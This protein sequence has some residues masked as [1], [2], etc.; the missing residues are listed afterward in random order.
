MRFI[1][2]VTCCVVGALGAQ[3]SRAR[4]TLPGFRDPFP[5]E[6]VTTSY[7]LNAPIGRAFA[8]IKGAFDDLRVPLDVND[9]RG[10]IV[11]NRSIKSVVAFAGYRLSRLVDCGSSPTGQNADTFRV[12]LV[13][14][15]LLD[16]TDATHT[17]VRVGFVGGAEPVAGAMRQ[18]VQCG[19]TGVIEA[20]LIELANKHL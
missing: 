14:L 12:S 20:R 17:K 1:L 4:I 19:S 16:S 18:G 11:G 13:L 7:D 3:P 5:I 10:E 15:A 2:A 8:A 6:D 9:A